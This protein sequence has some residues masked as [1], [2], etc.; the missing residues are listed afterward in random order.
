MSTQEQARELM[1][2]HRHHD[3]QL[4]ESM[5]NRAE[6]EADDP[7][8]ADSL[9]Q[10]HAR[11]LVAQHR[12]NDEDLQETMLSRAKAGITI[13]NDTSDASST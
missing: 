4:K 6:A 3:E 2:Q 5:L 13:S 12:H 9:T 8:S 11:G 1:T 7:N 10:K